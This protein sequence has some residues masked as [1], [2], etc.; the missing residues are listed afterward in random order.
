MITPVPVFLTFCICGLSHLVIKSCNVDLVFPG[1]ASGKRPT[2][3]CR[4]HKRHRFDP[5]VGKI[6]WRRAWQPAPAFLMGE[7]HGQRNL[8]GYIPQSRKEQDTATG[9]QGLGT[10]ACNVDVFL[11]I[12]FVKY[13]SCFSLFSNSLISDFLINFFLLLCIF[14]SFNKLPEMNAS[15]FIIILPHN[16]N[17]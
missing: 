7:F 17:I 5:Q 16:I 1:G 12:L 4:R 15:M 8:A 11:V 3:Q 6:P 9:L 14:F 13:N 10:Y 2:Y